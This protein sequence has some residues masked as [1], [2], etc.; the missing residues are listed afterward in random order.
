[1]EPGGGV[2]FTPLTYLVHFPEYEARGPPWKGP[3][4]RRRE[5][6]PERGPEQG[7]GRAPG[8]EAACRRG[9]DGHPER[10]RPAA[11]RRCRNAAR[12]GQPPVPPPASPPGGHRTPAGARPPRRAA[13]PPPGRRPA[14]AAPGRRGRPLVERTRCGVDLPGDIGGLG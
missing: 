4:P 13:S 6:T 9:R 2:T 5:M 7:R 12:S 8:P 3:A 1:M 14:A 11:P 10:G